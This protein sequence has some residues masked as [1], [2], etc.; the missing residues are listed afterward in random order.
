MVLPWSGSSAN[1][2]LSLAACSSKTTIWKRTQHTECLKDHRCH[3]SS[4]WSL[5]TDLILSTSKPRS[6]EIKGA[7]GADGPVTAE[8]LPV[9]KHGSFTPTLWRMELCFWTLMKHAVKS[10]CLA[11]ATHWESDE[12]V[13]R[14]TIHLKSGL[15]K[16]WNGVWLEATRPL[17]WAH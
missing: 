2:I 1:C 8:V 9:H 3:V 17:A 6:W 11:V 12:G 13:S 16:P 5:R 10:A 14:R 15:E 7:L 4:C